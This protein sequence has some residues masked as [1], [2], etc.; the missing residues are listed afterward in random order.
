[1]K[2]ISKLK[3][4]NK[5]LI[6]LSLFAISCLSAKKNS[7]PKKEDLIVTQNLGKKGPC[8]CNCAPT[9]SGCPQCVKDFLGLNTSRNYT[10]DW[11]SCTTPSG[12]GTVSWK[13]KI[14]FCVVNN[15][16]CDELCGKITDPPPFLPCLSNPDCIIFKTRCTANGISV[17]HWS[18]G[19][20]WEMSISVI[21]D[22]KFV[23]TCTDYNS[24]P[25]LFYN[26]VGEMY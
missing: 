6:I 10:I 12:A 19:I 16:N 13:S 3:N 5:L 17:S 15:G 20:D 9:L 23:V 11:L 1:M 14:E 25:P 21:E 22:P 2:T 8:P 26:C 7:E 24:N 4:T 18:N